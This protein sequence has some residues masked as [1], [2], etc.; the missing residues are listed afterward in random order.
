MAWATNEL[1]EL[2][3]RMA[4]QLRRVGYSDMAEAIK[5]IHWELIKDPENLTAQQRAPPNFRG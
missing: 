4:A 3:W 1:E 2:R 5:H